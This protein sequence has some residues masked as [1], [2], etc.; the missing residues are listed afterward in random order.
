ML[1]YKGGISR[2]VAESRLYEYTAKG[3]VPVTAAQAA[4]AAPKGGKQPQ[5][6]KVKE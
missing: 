4:P 6:N 1:I 5:K 2:N 3:Y